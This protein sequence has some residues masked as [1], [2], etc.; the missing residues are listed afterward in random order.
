MHSKNETLS[1]QADAFASWLLQRR[2]EGVLLVLCAVQLAIWIPHYLLWPMWADHDV[3]ATMAHAWIA[4]QLPYRDFLSNNFPGTTYLFWVL[5]H[6]T[7]WGNSIGLY[8][9]DVVL[10][11]LLGVILPLWSRRRFGS[12]L[13]GLTGYA[14][15]LSYYLSLD[16]TQTAQRDWHA[17]VMTVAGL[18]LAQTWRDRRG[19]IALALSVAIAFT[20]RPHV[21]LLLPAVLLT[22]AEGVDRPRRHSGAVATALAEWTVAFVVFLFFGFAPLMWSG[23]LDDLLRF[24][25]WFGYGPETN[26]RTLQD[27][28]VVLVPQL[29]NLRTIGIPACTL[30]LAWRSNSSARRLATIWFVAFLGALLY[31]PLS[32]HTHSYLTHPLWLVWCIHVA[33]IA[34]LIAGQPGVPSLRLAAIVL[35]LAISVTPKPRFCSIRG[36]LRATNA[37]V[38]GAEP[39]FLPAGYTHDYEFVPLYP[40]TDYLA[41]LNHIRTKTH[42]AIRVA[43]LLHGVAIT[44]PTARPSVFP[45]ESIT[46]LDVV[47]PGDEDRF[48]QSLEQAADSVVVWAPDDN[49]TRE[50][51][52]FVSAV[53][54]L[55]RM[56]AQFGEIEVWRR[57]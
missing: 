25:P 44:G 24:V 28:T 49:R 50:R 35:L 27:R 38:T 33:L 45:T 11:L 18:L 26:V 1:S 54:R 8:A 2:L 13:A 5:G 29:L 16:F 15:I 6:T 46:W 52:R 51:V 10:V 47:S 30:L 57:R 14:A 3:F 19:R 34:Y 23:V 21:V 37:L 53:H 17:A 48:L 7:G 39:A 12:A 22:V 42:S 31:D 32:P 40:W 9:F 41:T 20:I 43:N 4:G 55:Y 36:T 56:E